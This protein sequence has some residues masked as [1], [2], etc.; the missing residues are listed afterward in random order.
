MVK[1]LTISTWNMEELD[2]EDSSVWEARKP[3][4]KPMLDRTKADILLLHEVNSIEALND[5]REKYIKKYI[6]F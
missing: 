5:L 2:N 6:S 3:V 1:T 4:L